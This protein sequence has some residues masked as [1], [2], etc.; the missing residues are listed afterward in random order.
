MRSSNVVI[1]KPSFMVKVYLLAPIIKMLIALALFVFICASG[2]Y[3]LHQQSVN[4]LANLNQK[5]TM[6]IKEVTQEAKSYGEL[7]YLSKHAKTAKERYEAMVKQFPSQ[8]KIGELLANITKLGTAEGLKFVYFKPLSP[9]D[10]VFYAEV[11]VD[12]SVTGRFHQIGRFLS[13]VANLPNSVVAVNN[14]TLTR[15]NN[16]PEN[17]LSLE[18]T[19][20][21]YHALPT[22]LDIKT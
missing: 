19:A 11:P 12:I 13:G 22:S 8:F 14:F 3:I 9:V 4:A 17:L 10:H 20:T 6:L 1:K 15:L 21:L 2:I 16:S 7:V 18:F 5:K